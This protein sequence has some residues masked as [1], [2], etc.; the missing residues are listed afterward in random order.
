LNSKFSY[1]YHNRLLKVTGG[2]RNA[3]ISETARDNDIVTVDY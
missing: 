3:N 1:Q 2:L